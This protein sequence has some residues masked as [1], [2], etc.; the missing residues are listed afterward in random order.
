MKMFFLGFGSETLGHSNLMYEILYSIFELYIC[1]KSF[2]PQH[3]Q[4]EGCKHFIC[5][6]LHFL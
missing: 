5:T 6:L 2:V 1:D 4:D 3:F